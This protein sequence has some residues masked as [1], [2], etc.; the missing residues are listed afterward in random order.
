MLIME[1]FFL[2]YLHECALSAQAKTFQDLVLTQN[3]S[4]KTLIC[5]PQKVNTDLSFAY[6]WYTASFTRQ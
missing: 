1:C 4:H 3:D 5:T 2:S 6:V